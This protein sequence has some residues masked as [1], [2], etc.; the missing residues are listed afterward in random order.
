MSLDTL[1]DLRL[2][3]SKP[4]ATL[5]LVAGPVPD[6]LA[7]WPDVIGVTESPERMDWRPVVGLPLAVLVADGYVDIGSR[8]FDCA[9]AAGCIPVGVAFRDGGHS[10]DDAARAPLHRLWELVCQS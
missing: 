3:R 9:M 6:Y 8:A 2:S 1:R 5:K 4:T 7:W 10:I